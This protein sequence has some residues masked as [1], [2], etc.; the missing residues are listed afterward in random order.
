MPLSSGGERH[1]HQQGFHSFQISPHN[2]TTRLR[3]TSV[4]CKDVHTLSFA[5]S[6]AYPHH[7][8]QRMPYSPNRSANN[9]G[10]SSHGIYSSP[11]GSSLDKRG[12]TS[13][14]TLVSTKTISEKFS[15]AA[16][17]AQWG[18]SPNSSEPDDFLHNP[19][20]RRDRKNDNGD[21]IFSA[22]GFSNLGCLLVLGTSLLGLFAGYPMAIHFTTKIMSKNG[23]YNLGGTNATGQVPYIGNFGLI[24]SDTPQDVYTITSYTDGSTKMKLVFSDEFNTDGRTFYPGDDPYWEAVSLHYWQ[25]NNMEWYDP[26][27]ITTR[28]GALQISLSKEDPASNHN[29]SY[30]GGMMT[31]WNKFCFTSGMILASVT[32]PGA[33]NVMGL[34]PAIWAM[35]NLGRAGYGASLDGM[36]PYTYD[37]CDVGTLKNQTLNGLPATARTSGPGGGTLS[38]LPGQRLSRCTCTGESHPGPI[39]AD[40]TYVGRSAPEID[41]FEAQVNNGIGYVSQSAQW[42][43]FNPSYEWFN[44]SDTLIIYDPTVTVLNEYKGGVY[45]Q[46]TSGISQTAQD[47]YQLTGGYFATYGFEYV[48]GYNDA[49]ISWINDNKVAWTIKA[50]GMDAD[51]RVEISARPVPQEPMYL[52]VNLGMSENFGTVDLQHMQFPT[53]MSVDWIRVYQDPHNIN[54]GCDPKD[55]PTKAYIEEYLEAYTN[56]NLTTWTGSS[57][58]GGFNQPLPKNSLIDDC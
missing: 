3:N 40:G 55:F 39:H 31:T 49:Y 26:S 38:Y 36:W 44:T 16:D 4:V 29:L 23:G 53:I 33:S 11:Y 20:P 10:I 2:F 27:A 5:M 50:G 57:N 25:T 37:A 9:S 13:S 6:G 45:Q 47:C 28:N 24:D 17:P 51:S 43:P 15:L 8:P 32:L 34:W 54:I 52:L 42:G 30:R 19:D 46:A 7:K 18:L 58:R 41:V 14:S 21:T 12:Y 35:G 48:A 22:R 56:P 1:Q